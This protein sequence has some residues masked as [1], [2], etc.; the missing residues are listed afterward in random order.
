MTGPVFDMPA[1]PEGWTSST[2][3]LV[4]II[5]PLGQAIAWLALSKRNPIVGFSVRFNNLGDDS[6]PHQWKDVVV[7]PTASVRAPERHHNEHDSQHHWTLVERDPA[8]CELESAPA[9]TPAGERYRFAASLTDARLSLMLETRSHGHSS[10]S[11]QLCL[12]LQFSS[13]PT[14]TIEPEETAEADEPEEALTSTD[15][16]HT[17][18]QIQISIMTSGC[19]CE[20]QTHVDGE[21]T[22]HTVTIRCSLA[23]E[24]PSLTGKPVWMGVDIGLANLSGN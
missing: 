5:D 1:A 11:N 13:Q 12:K 24:H 17:A 9:Q 14:I 22:T 19:R 20:R 3:Q 21:G 10:Y 15:A 18:G 2:D 8:A 7:D 16:S 4:R 23:Q 6:S